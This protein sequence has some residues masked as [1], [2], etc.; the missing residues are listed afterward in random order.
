MQWKMGRDRRARH[1]A[2]FYRP[3][4][5]SIPES[6]AGTRIPARST[7][8]WE[9]MDFAPIKAIAKRAGSGGLF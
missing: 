6:R 3:K 7:V 1:A 4:S 2:S 8:I 9:M 5:A